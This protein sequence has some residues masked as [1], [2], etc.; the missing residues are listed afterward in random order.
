MGDWQQ[1]RRAITLRSQRYEEEKMNRLTN[2]VLKLQLW[3]D[4]KGQ[5]LVEYALMAGF[6]AVAA[7]AIMPNAVVSISQI[8]SQVGSVLSN[9]NGS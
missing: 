8:F 1:Y 5:D 6:V 7:G 3:A 2:L 4:T 9:A